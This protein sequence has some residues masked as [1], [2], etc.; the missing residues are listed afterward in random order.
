MTHPINN[1]V[2]FQKPHYDAKPDPTK[3]KKRFA[4]ALAHGALDS[5]ATVGSLVPGGQIIAAAANGIKSITGGPMNDQMA[6]MWEMQRES[7]AFNLQYLELQTAIQDD[8]RQFSTLSNLLKARHDTAKSAINN[9][10]V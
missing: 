8:N 10:Q 9:I 3:P 4:G 2:R 1:N 6:Q 7:Q 5:I